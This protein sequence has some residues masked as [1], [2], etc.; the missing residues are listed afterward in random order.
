MTRTFS[1]KSLHPD[2]RFVSSRLWTAQR[3]LPTVLSGVL[4]SFGTK[5]K[6]WEISTFLPKIFEIIQ[7]LEIAGLMANNSL[8]VLAIL[9]LWGLKGASMETMVFNIK[10]FPR[11]LHTKMKIEAVREGITLR[12][13]IKAAVEAKLASKTLKPRKG[14]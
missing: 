6:R 2:K 14:E 4:D 1:H 13:W 12:D 3:S 8:T 10:G 11:A 5:N 7:K 9:V